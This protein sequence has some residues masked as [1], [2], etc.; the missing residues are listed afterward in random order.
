MRARSYVE[1]ERMEDPNGVMCYG[2]A[3][4]LQSER[5]QRNECECEYAVEMME[6]GE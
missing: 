3:S 5:S 4:E 6:E 1:H 2:E